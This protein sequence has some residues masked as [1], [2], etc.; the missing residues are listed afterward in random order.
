MDRPAGEREVGVP[1]D[2]RAV[3]RPDPVLLK[4]YTI[5]A[6]LTGPAFPFVWL[7]SF[8][9]YKTLRYRFDEEGVWMAWGVLFKR[10]IN[11]AYRR[12]QDIHVTRGLIQRWLGLASVAVQTASGSATPEM[13]IEG[14]LDADG[15][16]DFLYARM[17]GARDERTPPSD[18]AD[19]ADEA[20]RLLGG[21][22]EGVVALRRR[23]ERLEE[24]LAP[25]EE[26]EP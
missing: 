15:L 19:G 9:R 1:F 3:N 25:G 14:V 11:L 24:R 16:R 2:P 22:L 18:A 8:C 17:R 23:V 21:I 12:I 13:T 4:H 10:E 5:V 26:R 6:L 20:Q 7:A